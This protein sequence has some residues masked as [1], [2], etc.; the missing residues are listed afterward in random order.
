LHEKWA[1]PKYRQEVIEHLEERGIDLQALAEQSKAP[2]SDPFDLLCHVAFNAPLRTRRDRAEAL[3][4]K[5]PDFWTKFPPE[6]R[7]VLNAI[8]DKYAEHG[9]RELVVPQ[10]LEVPPLSSMGNVLEL[11]R[12]FGGEENLAAAVRELQVRLYA[13]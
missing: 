6:A 8:L 10:V 9:V 4:R 7:E 1:D 11:A 12:R 2:D 3:R 5:T 13:A